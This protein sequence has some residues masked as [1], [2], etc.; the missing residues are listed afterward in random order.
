MFAACTFCALAELV[1]DQEVRGER[2]QLPEE[3]EEEHQVRRG[4]DAVH[5]GDEQQ[6][7]GIVAGDAVI[8]VMLHVADRVERGGDR[9][10]RDQQDED[11]AQAV[12]VEPQR[13]A[14]LRQR[15]QRHRRFRPAK[16]RDRRGQQREGARSRREEKRDP[17]GQRLVPR[18]EQRHRRADDAQA[19][20]VGYGL[21]GCQVHVHSA[22]VRRLPA[23][24]FLSRLRPAASGS[25]SRGSDISDPVRRDA[26]WTPSSQTRV[27]LIPI[28]ITRRGHAQLKSCASRPAGSG[29]LYFRRVH[30]NHGARR[31]AEVDGVQEHDVVV[32]AAGEH[33]RDFSGTVPATTAVDMPALLE[34]LRQG[35]RPGRRR[36]GPC[37]RCPRRR[38]PCG[39]ASASRSSSLRSRFKSLLPACESAR[40]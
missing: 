35:G 32:A 24:H 7:V 26:G 37:C 1:A 3:A 20:R 13:R 12:H 36:P 15:R 33:A 39:P 8:R 30:K 19:H 17:A 6:E 27:R 34:L 18:K 31:R 11:G 5:A 14:V 2:H 29:L 25:A 9:D 40:A 21:C 16:K 28:S 23:K 38:S 10:R 4:H 22:S